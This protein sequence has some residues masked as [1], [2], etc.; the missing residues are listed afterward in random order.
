[1]QYLLQLSVTWR[2]KILEIPGSNVLPE[3][4]EPSAEELEDTAR[5]IMSDSWDVAE[6]SEDGGSDTGF[7][8]WTG[9]EDAELIE[10]LEYQGIADAYRYGSDHT[11]FYEGD[12]TEYANYESHLT[13]MQTSRWQRLSAS[14]RK[15]SRRGS[16]DI[17]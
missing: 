8:E 11:V 17:E 3:R 13:P 6:G 1:M 15:R 5:E 16:W 4:W 12:N 14:P 10:E 9:Q 7:D 2:N